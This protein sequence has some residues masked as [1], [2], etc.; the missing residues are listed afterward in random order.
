MHDHIARRPAHH[1]FIAKRSRIGMWSF[2]TL[3]I[4]VDEGF[5][6]DDDVPVHRVSLPSS[7]NPF[8]KRS[9][10]EPDPKPDV[11]DP[12]DPGHAPSPVPTNV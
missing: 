6:K 5:P 2:R 9:E 8:L 11:R 10:T 7:F 1:P 12:P 4:Q 3:R